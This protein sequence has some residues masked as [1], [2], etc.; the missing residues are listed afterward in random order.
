[1]AEYIERQAVIDLLK[2]AGEESGSPVV[3]I[4]LMIEAVQDDVPTADVAP[5][6]RGH[7]LTWEERFPDRATGKNL[8]VFCSVC[9]NHADF[10]SSY[11]PHCGAKMDEEG[12][13]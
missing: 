1:M 2:G 13:Q 10:S 6:V 3:D 5:V 12:K 11:C 8:G 4:E 7:W 9:G